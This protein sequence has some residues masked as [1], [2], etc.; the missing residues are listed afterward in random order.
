M[1]SVRKRKMARSSVKKAT[2]KNKDKQRKINITGNPIIAENWDYSLTLSQNYKKLGLRAKLQKPAGGQE[3][4]LNKIVKKQPLSKPAFDDSDDEEDEEGNGQAADELNSDGEFDEDKIPEGEARIQRDE[5][6][7][8]IKVV[9]GKKK[10]FDIDQ[11]ID[12]LK[13]NAEHAEEKTDTV[14]QLEAYANRPL[15]AKQ[16]VQSEREEEWL[17]K[18]YKKHGD[19]YKK[20]VFDR[21]LNINQQTEADLRRRIVKWKQRHNID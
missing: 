16:R 14:K 20:M 9:Y 3:A 15:V 10:A 2:R 7:N 19:N 13:K 6:G 1:A 5:H 4:D 18:L 12:E 11:D 8:A 21:K 17:E